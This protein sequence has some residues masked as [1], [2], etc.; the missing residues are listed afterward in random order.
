MEHTD[1]KIHS[2]DADLRQ[3]DDQVIDIYKPNGKDYPIIERTNNAL[4]WPD[5]IKD[6]I[7]LIDTNRLKNNKINLNPHTN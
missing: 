7:D 1:K 3:I 2:G 6:E 4:L 5:K